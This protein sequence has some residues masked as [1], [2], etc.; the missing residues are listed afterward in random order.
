MEEKKAPYPPYGAWRLTDKGYQVCAYPAHPDR[1]VTWSGGVDAEGYASGEGILQ[2]YMD[3]SPDERYE[4]TLAGGIYSGKGVITYANGAR[5]EGEFVNHFQNG[6]GII[7]WSCGSCYQGDWI[8]NIR[9]GKGLLTFAN[10]DRYE[11]DFSYNDQHGWGIMTYANGDRYEGEWVDDKR[12]GKGVY[13]RADGERYDGD[14]TAGRFSGYGGIWSKTDCGNKVWDD[15]PQPTARTANWSGGVDAEGYA[16]GQGVL[17]W[18]IA[19]KPDER[20]EG[21][22][23]QGKRHGSGICIFDNG[24]R[25]EGCWVDGRTEGKGTYFYATGQR[26]EMEKWVK[27]GNTKALKNLRT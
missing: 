9:E 21:N 22:L 7:T 27:R 8:D 13:I 12:D 10:G 16:S 11:G 26:Y 19:G 3:G 17:Q 6:K 24:D 1:T 4:G 25:Y 5:A 14:W 15:D 20:Y 18:H 23:L 2:W